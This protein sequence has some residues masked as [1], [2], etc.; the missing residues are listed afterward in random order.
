M[1]DNSEDAANQPIR[2]ELRRLEE[3]CT[4][5]GKAQFNAAD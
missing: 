1:G 3:D 2:S 5:S 4:Y